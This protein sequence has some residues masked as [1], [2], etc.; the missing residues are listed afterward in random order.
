M[1]GAGQARDQVTGYNTQLMWLTGLQDKVLV[2]QCSLLP[3]F[4]MCFEDLRQP[5]LRHHGSFGMEA[6]HLHQEVG[7][8]VAISSATSAWGYPSLPSARAGGHPDSLTSSL[9]SKEMPHH[10]SWQIQI[11]GKE[12]CLAAET[13]LLLPTSQV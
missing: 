1:A 6:P 12:F 2:T 5:A 11:C 4:G 7:G 8:G 13:A 3:F 9:D 10:S